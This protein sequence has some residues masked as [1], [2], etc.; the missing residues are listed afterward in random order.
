MKR[1]ASFCVD[2]SEL[3]KG[4]YI[5]RTDADI[6]T[7]DLRMAEPNVDEPL[8]SAAAHTIEHIL[9]TYLRNSE[10][11]DNIIYVGPMG[12]LTGFYVLTREIETKVL[13]PLLHKAFLYIAA[14]EGDIPGATSR[15]CGNYSLQDLPKAKTLS[16]EYA[17]IVE[18]L[19]ETKTVYPKLLA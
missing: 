14:F 5:S 4:V 3:P 6:V 18:I 19:D 12:C 15:E 1:I 9:A 7:Y 2:H 11:S 13:L 8:S 17:S 10:Y 16:E